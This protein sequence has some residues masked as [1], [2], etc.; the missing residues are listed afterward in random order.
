MKNDNLYS[1]LT[2]KE[3]DGLSFPAKLLLRQELLQ[4]NILDFG[5]GFGKDVE[6]LSKQGYT[7]TGYDPHYQPLYPTETFDTI[8]C[9]YVLN[10][11]KQQEQSQ[12]IMEISKLLKP[13]GSAYFAVRRDIAQE[14]YRIHKIHQQP[15]YQC[16][17][18]LPFHSLYQNDNCE[19][20][21][22]QHYNQLQRKNNTNCPFCAVDTDRELVM[23][24]ATTFAI[25]DKYPVN[26]GHTL[27]VPKRH[28]AN[29]FELN[30]KEQTAC[31]LL[32]NAAK[33]TLDKIFNP[34]GYNIGVNIAE[35]AGQTVPHVHIHLIPRY[36][37]DVEKPA[38]GVRGVIPG[39]QEY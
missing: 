6:E 11:L 7:I 39:K 17:V 38:G 2:A 32:I 8:L 5:C 34:D 21:R 37:G 23:E 28:V 36:K 14:G 24:S 13:T 27:I 31:L 26:P 22:Y 29:Y 35:V 30:L 19:I 33:Q 3:R 9:F 20:Y 18:L 1:H 16:N 4:G 25:Y 15:T 12:V 10:V